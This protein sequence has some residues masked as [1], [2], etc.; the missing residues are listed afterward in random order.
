MS[1]NVS[2][3]IVVGAVVVIVLLAAIIWGSK[4]V[5]LKMLGVEASVDPDEKRTVSVADKIDLDHAEVGNVTGERI[6]AGGAAARDV[7]VMNDAVVRGG[8]I[9]DITGVDVAPDP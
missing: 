3:Q 6:A 1:D 5:R 2:I 7:R 9:G 4:R 8:K